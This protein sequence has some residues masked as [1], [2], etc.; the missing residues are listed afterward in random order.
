MLHMFGSRMLANI[1]FSLSEFFHKR[2]DHLQ[3]DS[4][5][6]VHDQ[7]E[8]TFQTPYV[9]MLREEAQMDFKYNI[10]VSAANWIL[11]A[12]YLVIPGTFT[13]L[14]KSNL[15]GETLRE[16]SAGRVVLR[17]I[18][19]PPLLAIACLFVVIG[20]AALAW[21]LRF[22]KIRRNYT[23]LINKILM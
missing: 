21:L 23:W 6:L 14:Q 18:Q 22:P 11:L 13:S 3:A 8:N 4:N 19:N 12:G 10:I 17:T 15:V 1:N 5:D 2:S 20:S 16:K 9:R 7:R